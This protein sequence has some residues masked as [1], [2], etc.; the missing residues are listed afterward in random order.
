MVMKKMRSGDNDG[1]SVGERQNSD[2]RTALPPPPSSADPN[3]RASRSATSPSW[4][5]E[6]RHLWYRFSRHELKGCIND[7]K[8]M[9]HLL[10]NKF[11]FS[12]YSILMLIGTLFLYLFNPSLSLSFSLCEFCFVKGD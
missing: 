2:P 7:A 9:R 8:C 10:I 12:P 6:G 4:Q 1:L 3:P 11:K 5:E